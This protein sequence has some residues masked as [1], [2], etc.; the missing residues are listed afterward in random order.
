MAKV[1]YRARATVARYEDNTIARC[2]N[3]HTE[4]Y[5][6]IHI[7]HLCELNVYKGKAKAKRGRQDKAA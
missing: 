2:A 6:Y 5:T 1:D 3:T 7:C 4:I